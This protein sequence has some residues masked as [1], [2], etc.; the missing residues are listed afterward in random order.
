MKRR[1]ILLILLA[2]LAVAAIFSFLFPERT[3][4]LADDG[5]ALAINA[6]H[7]TLGA[8]NDGYVAPDDDVSASDTVS[9][10]IGDDLL[11]ATT[12]DQGSDGTA[13][14]IF[15]ENISNVASSAPAL[16]SAKKSSAEISTISDNADDAGADGPTG[17]S[18]IDESSTIAALPPPICAITTSNVPSREVLLSEIAW[19]GSLPSSG[20]T[21]TQASEHEW[22][23]LK[24]NSSNTIALS[25]WTVLDRSGTIKIIFTNDDAIPADGYLLLVRGTDYTGGLSNAG[26][27]LEVF[28]P[29]CALSDVLDASAGWPAGNNTTKQTLERD[30]DGVGWH[31][32]IPPGGTPG[33]VNSDPAPA[34]GDQNIIIAGGSAVNAP[35][36]PPVISSVTNTSTTSTASTSLSDVA[37]T[38]GTS[39]ASTE[40]ILIVAV[41]IGGASSTNDFVK[42]FDPST[43]VIDLSGWKLRKKTSTGTD[44]SLKVI[45][46]G[47]SIAAG[48]YFTW[49]NSA[50]G[51]G[52]ALGADV[53][54]SETLAADNSVAL[55][56]ANGTII[57]EV[58]WGTGSDQYVEGDPYPTNPVSNQVLARIAN[59]GV[60]VDTE[61]NAADFT[62]QSQ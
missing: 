57:D 55:M 7:A 29:T 60:C 62:L 1:N 24:N 47:S 54:S 37:S 56:D 38:T 58:A 12:T 28:D 3:K 33:A 36:V 59:V 21:A 17:T 23:E 16:A 9:G 20:E 48:G 5:S 45:P 41:A 18:A 51:F 14:S 35:T 6:W 22:I 13:A 44:S 50:G 11:D 27:L 4:M 49:A 42:L 26:D 39:T 25:G 10:D 46:N 30:A 31:T 32:S 8:S 40:K 61:D 19:M 34:I 15:S 43:A 53:T 52:D 2:M